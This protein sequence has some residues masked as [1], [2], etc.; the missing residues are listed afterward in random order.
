MVTI[1]IIITSTGDLQPST[2]VSNQLPDKSVTT[3][4]YVATSYVSS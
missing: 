2:A 4:R 3:H 1:V